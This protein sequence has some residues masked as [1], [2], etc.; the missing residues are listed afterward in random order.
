MDRVLVPVDGSS[1]AERALEEAL[2]LFPDAEIVA[3]HVAQVTSFPAD[4][5]RTPYELA[6]AEGERVLE[7]ATEIA[8]ERGRTLE[9]VLTEGNAGREI[10]EF[11]RENNVDRVVMGST[12]RSG[13]PRL[14]LGSVAETVTRRSPVSVTIVR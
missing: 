10:L 6:R 2:E 12:G 8:A 5:E 1:Q 7:D 3:L 13:V 14:L 11:V 4:R 9:T